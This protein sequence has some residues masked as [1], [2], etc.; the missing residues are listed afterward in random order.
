MAHIIYIIFSIEE[1]NIRV[2]EVTFSAIVLTFNGDSTFTVSLYAALL[3]VFH[4]NTVSI[5]QMTFTALVT[6]LIAS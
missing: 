3:Y 4:S 1:M 6:R 5:R 2:K